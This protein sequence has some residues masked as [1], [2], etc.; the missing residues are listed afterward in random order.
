MQNCLIRMLDCFD[1]VFPA[2]LGRCVGFQGER[3]V[4]VFL[5]RGISRICSVDCS[6]A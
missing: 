5:K 6:G 3:D 4:S 1:C 2:G